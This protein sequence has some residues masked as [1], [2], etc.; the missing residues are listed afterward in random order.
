MNDSAVK[1]FGYQTLRLVAQELVKAVR[2]SVTINWTVRE[3]VR[4]SIHAIIKRILRNYGYPP[5][6]QARAT[7]IALAQA[8]VLCMGW[9]VAA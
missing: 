6:K 9:I 4:A 1:V 5:G 8:E 3:N 2:N 7:D